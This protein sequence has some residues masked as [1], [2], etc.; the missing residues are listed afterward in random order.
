MAWVLLVVAGIF[1]IG[2]AIALKYTEGF[3]R[4]WPTV[5]FTLSMLVS[6]WLLAVALKTIPVGTGYAVWTGIGAAGT[7]ILGIVLLG[8]SRDGWRIFSIVLIITGIVS[9]KLSSS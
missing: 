9:L 7:A 6:V 2:W 8:E 1:E 3:S 5:L 4:L